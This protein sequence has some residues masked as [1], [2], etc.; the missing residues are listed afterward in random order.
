MSDDRELVHS[1]VG[2]FGDL[3]LIEFFVYYLPLV[4]GGCIVLAFA[5]F[6]PGILVL[7]GGLAYKLSRTLGLLLVVIGWV[8]GT[9]VWAAAALTGFA[10]VFGELLRLYFLPRQRA[11]LDRSAEDIIRETRPRHDPQSG[12]SR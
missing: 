5:G 10:V 9:P 12:Q 6:W 4:V 1:Y 2:L 8:L 7:F 11:R 3:M